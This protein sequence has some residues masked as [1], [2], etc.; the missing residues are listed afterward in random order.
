MST[1]TMNK[2]N[3]RR[4]W[5]LLAVV[6]VVAAAAAVALLWD[7]PAAVAPGGQEAPDS[8]QA[9]SYEGSYELWEAQELASYRYT[10]QVGCFCLVE[11]TRPVVIEVHDGEV[12]SVTYADDGSAADPALFE[13]YDSIDDLFAVISEAEAQDPARLDVVYDEETGVPLSVDIDISEL[14]ADEELY[15]TVSGFEALR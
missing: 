5:V 1:L 3:N 4:T 14:M 12:A 8:P 9:G 13:R 7:G 2:K 15:L 10:L 6:V 11:M